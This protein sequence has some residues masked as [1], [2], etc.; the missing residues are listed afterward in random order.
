MKDI[1]GFPA[2]R[3]KHYRILMVMASMAVKW[4][5]FLA[6]VM[7]LGLQTATAATSFKLELGK[8][9]ALDK[10][11]PASFSCE[12]LINETNKHIIKPYLIFEVIAESTAAPTFSV[13]AVLFGTSHNNQTH[14]A[15]SGSYFPLSGT[16]LLQSATRKCTMQRGMNIITARTF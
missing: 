1:F 11:Y 4:A 5:T 3:K 16:I 8:E 6:A 15:K 14:R 13:Y 12:L 2:Q 10:N 7:V 9:Y